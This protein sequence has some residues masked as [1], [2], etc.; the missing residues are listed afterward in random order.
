[1]VN[2]LIIFIQPHYYWAG[3]GYTSHWHVFGRL[4]DITA[5]LFIRPKKGKEYPTMLNYV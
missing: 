1:M 3:A 4:L 2:Q 5:G